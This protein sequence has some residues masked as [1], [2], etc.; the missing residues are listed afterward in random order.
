M[1]INVLLVDDSAVVR[2]MVCHGLEKDPSIKVISTAADGKIAIDMA[3]QH[4]PDI[5]ILDIEMPHMD[6]ITALPLLLQE[7]PG[8]RII[9]AS[10]LTLKSAQIS[11][12]A[13]SLGAADYIAKPDIDGIDEYYQQLKEK[14]KALGAN[15]T[16][17]KLTT[18]AQVT[19]LLMNL[20]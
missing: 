5:I 1:I 2:R 10:R 4:K 9:M 3:K 19:S 13:L 7:V 15:K 6:G 8:V 18:F 12:Q 17:K 20:L 14:I 11:F 16:F